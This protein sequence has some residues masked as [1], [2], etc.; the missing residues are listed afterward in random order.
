MGLFSFLR[1]K[2]EEA[3]APQV[4]EITCELKRVQRPLSAVHLE[5]VDKVRANCYG[6]YLFT[7]EAI[8]VVRGINPATNRK[9]KRTYTASSEAD[10]IQQAEASGLAGPFEITVEPADAATESQLAYAKNLGVN[11]PKGACKTDLSALLSRAEE[12]DERAALPDVLEFLA[13]RGWRGSA[14]IGYEAMLAAVRRFLEEPREGLAFYAYY[15]DQAEH[16][17]PLGNFDKAPNKNQYLAFADYALQSEKIVEHYSRWS[18]DETWS[19]AKTWGV[20]KDY[21]AYCEGKK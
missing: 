2:K 13:D 18:Q 9:N 19:T 15:I 1:K 5:G 14:L 21:R 17:R 20:Y 16:K 10:A 6:N 7:P 12:N 3:P 4:L 8:F 11:V